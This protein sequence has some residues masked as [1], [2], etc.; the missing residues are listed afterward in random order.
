MRS[1]QS[2]NHGSD[3]AQTSWCLCE[4]ILK[5]VSVRP[6]ISSPLDHVY[7]NRIVD[8]LIA[9]ILLI[10]SGEHTLLDDG[11]VRNHFVECFSAGSWGEIVLV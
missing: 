3:G 8:H 2:Y 11:N 7:E 1:S 10:K 5:I 4:I 9:I 6:L